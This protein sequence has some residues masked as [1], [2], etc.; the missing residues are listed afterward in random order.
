MHD[1]LLHYHSLQ[2]KRLVSSNLG[3]SEVESV[4][5]VMVPPV[6]EV[7]GVSLGGSA[8]GIFLVACPEDQSPNQISYAPDAA[9]Y[10]LR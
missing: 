8:V 5:D 1:E 9:E 2:R 7:V 6:A 3:K 4:V 10:Y